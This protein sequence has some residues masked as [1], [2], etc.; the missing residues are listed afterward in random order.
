MGVGA[1]SER[2]PETRGLDIFGER[3]E[4][5]HSSFRESRE[6]GKVFPEK[7]TA[8]L[9]KFLSLGK[10]RPIFR[11]PHQSV[12]CGVDGAARQKVEWHTGLRQDLA[13]FRMNGETGLVCTKYL[14]GLA[15]FFKA[16]AQIESWKRK[17]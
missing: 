2:V 8:S 15:T 4:H 14:A 5:F 17:V 10:D 6:M 13:G 11:D 9:A 1:G 3:I 16:V 7:G 12:K